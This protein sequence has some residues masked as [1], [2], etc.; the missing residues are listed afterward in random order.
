MIEYVNGYMVNSLD[1]R[2]GLG[3]F[4]QKKKPAWQYGAWN[5]VGG[6]I[7]PGETP[8]EA[9]CREF[10]EEADVQ[11]RPDEWE[12]AVVLQGDDFIVY[13]FRSVQSLEKMQECRTKT[14]EP[15]VIRSCISMLT[16]APVLANMLWSLPMILSQ[17]IVFPIIVSDFKRI[18]IIDHPA[19]QQATIKC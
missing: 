11:T 10:F 12:L 5:G 7:E 8:E 6:K 19:L 3:V 15:I 13:N 2:T 17:D 18:G 1:L 16:D 4:L 9:M 14:A